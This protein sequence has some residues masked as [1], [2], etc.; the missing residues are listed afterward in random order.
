MRLYNAKSDDI[1]PRNFTLADFVPH[2]YEGV[3][4]FESGP[5]F[6]PSVDYYRF[7]CVLCA[8]PP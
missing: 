4:L 2:Q 3:Y 6:P 1:N 5:V 7:S 8:P